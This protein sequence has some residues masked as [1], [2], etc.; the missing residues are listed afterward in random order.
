MQAVKYQDAKN[1]STEQDSV[2]M[3]AWALPP[4]DVHPESEGGVTGM[5]SP[6]TLEAVAGA[7]QHQIWHR[8]RPPVT[9]LDV[10]GASL[11][12]S[13]WESRPLTVGFRP[14]RLK[15]SR[16]YQYKIILRQASGS[17]GSGRDEGAKP[18]LMVAS[19]NVTL[20]LIVRIEGV[21]KGFFDELNL[22]IFE[23]FP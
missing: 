20:G 6:M 13:I 10:H 19:L 15:Q 16:L 17:D 12:F 21:W 9:L 22:V 7:V 11:G 23:D 8:R 1:A 4:T 18:L 2:H 14:E 5:S 3:R